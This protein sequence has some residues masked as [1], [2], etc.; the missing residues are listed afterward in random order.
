MEED[1]PTLIADDNTA[2]SKQ[3]AVFISQ[4]DNYERAPRVEGFVA[5]FAYFLTKH[6]AESHSHFVGKAECRRLMYL[7][8][9]EERADG[10][11]IKL[12]A[13]HVNQSISPPAREKVL[14]LYEKSI[15]PLQTSD[16]RASQHCLADEAKHFRSAQPTPG[17]LVNASLSATARL[18]PSYLAGA[19]KR[20]PKPENESN[21]LVAAVSIIISDALFV[22]SAWC[23]IALEVTENKVEHIAETLF[24]AHLETTAELR[25]LYLPGGTRVLP[26]PILTL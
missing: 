23:Q 17:V 18:L 13:A 6:G 9:E 1:T 5:W 10:D 12:L 25:Y 16:D 11:H 24:G 4:L 20:I 3:A 8:A 14:C 19:V 15:R 2:L 7:L 21:S 22:D 26:N